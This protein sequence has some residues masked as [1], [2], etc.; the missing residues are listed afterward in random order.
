M[1]GSHLS[2]AVPMHANQAFLFMH[3]VGLA[4]GFS[5]SVA[6][7]VMAVLIARAAPADRAVLAR[8]PPTMSKVGSI[9]LALLWITGAMLLY[10]K[11]GGLASLP[12]QFHVKLTAVA[13]LTVTTLYIHHLQRLVQAGRAAVIERIEAFGKIATVLAVIALLFAVLTFG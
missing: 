9:G 13:L 5:V 7:I 3:F 10:A 12:W 11:W 6:N 4:L 1:L 8:F 2:G